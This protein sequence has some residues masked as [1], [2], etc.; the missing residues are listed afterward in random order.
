[1]T[2]SAAQRTDPS[3]ASRADVLLCG[4]GLANSLIALRLK[5][6]RPNLK[7]LLL[8]RAATP[9][10]AHTWSFFQ[11]DVPAD[12]H[13]WL[14]PL[15][16][17]SWPAYRVAFPDFERR[18]ATGYASLTSATLNAAVE[19]ALGADRVFGVDAVEV[20]PD[21]VI[22]ADGSAF[23][24]PLVIDGRGARSSPVLA[25]GFQKFVGLEV[26]TATPHG[27]AEP[28]VMDANLPQLDGYRFVYVLPFAPDRLLIEDTRYSDGPALDVEA[29]AREVKAYAAARGW[30]IAAVERVET[31]VLPVALAGDIDAFWAEQDDGV[32]RSG[33]R[34]ALFHPTTGYSLPDAA[35]LADAVAAAPELTS[36]AIARLVR[37]QSV[38]AWRERCFFRLLNRMMFL[39]AEPDR[40]WRVLAR[41]YRLP[42]PLIERFYAG[43]LTLTDKARLLAGEPPVPIL[44]AF[45][46]MPESAA[47][48]SRSLN[49]AS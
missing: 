6:R 20:A 5:A 42:Q 10:D 45:R 46:A 29:L 21:R 26:R 7:V 33:L 9:E 12:T 39:A 4:A 1:M 2:I 35:R 27:V 44:E 40:R 3:A 11:T 8:E 18:I 17:V 22:A 28:T 38:A 31:G 41:F 16:H 13:A 14:K 36:A 19:V 25:L 49:A 37:E 15:F 24:A 32:P 23:A 30:R 34:A 47:F 43:R 48:L